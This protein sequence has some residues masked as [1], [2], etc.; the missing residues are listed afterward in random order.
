MKLWQR[1]NNENS[2]KTKQEKQFVRELSMLLL[3]S[4]SGGEWWYPS[5]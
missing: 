5:G 3:R 1:V 4:G 2:E